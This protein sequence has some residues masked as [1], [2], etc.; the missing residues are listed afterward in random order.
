[1]TTIDAHQHFWK[2]DAVQHSWIGEDMAS[3]RRDFL[4]EDLA[5]VLAQNGVD[6]CV[7]VQADQTREETHFLLDEASRH[8]FIKGVVGWVDLQSPEIETLLA[9]YAHFAALKGFRHILQGEQQ[10]DLCLQKSFLNGI[11]LLE[12]FGFTYDILILKDQLQF[13]PDLVSRFPN[14]RFVLDHLAK[15]AIK[16][17]EIGTWKKDIEEVAK[18]ENVYCKVSGMVTEADL[19]HWKEADLVPYLDVVTNAFGTH[20]ILYGSDWPVCLAAG[21]YSRVINVVRSYFESYSLHEQ[22]LVFGGNALKFYNL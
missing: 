5:P 20:R 19:Q 8:S 3:I 2:Y 16:Q 15:P 14:Q 22:Q 11:S 10:R 13:I 17:G 1:M 7:A 12:Q 18:Y 21:D 4:P 6:G 9:S